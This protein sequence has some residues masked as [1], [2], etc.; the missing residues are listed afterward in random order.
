MRS[1]PARTI[2][3]LCR[4]RRDLVA[5]W[6]AWTRVEKGMAVLTVLAVLA[7]PIVLDTAGFAG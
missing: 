3:N 6:K 2:P 7:T 1:S 5:D 4:A